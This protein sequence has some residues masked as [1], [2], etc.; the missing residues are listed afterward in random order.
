METIPPNANDARESKIFCFA[1]LADKHIGTIY[2]D[3]TGH[4]PA[5]SLERNYYFLIAYDYDNNYIFARPM[6]DVKDSTVV[7]TYKTIF[8]ELKRGKYQ[9]RA[10]FCDGDPDMYQDF[11][12]T[13]LRNLF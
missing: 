1:A 10:M 3:C 6:K 13:D 8:E 9:P 11:M 2:T 5:V 4:L 12:K 7:S